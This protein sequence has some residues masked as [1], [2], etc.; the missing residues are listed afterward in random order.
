Q[1]IAEKLYQLGR[2]HQV[3]CVTH[4]PLVAAMADAHYHV[5]KHVV[6]QPAIEKTSSKTTKTKAAKAAVA[7]EEAKAR[8]KIAAQIDKSDTDTDKTAQR[9][10][11]AKKIQ[12]TDSKSGNK[13]SE[14]RTIVKV[15]PLKKAEERRDELAQ[16]AGG[17]SD[18]DAIAFANS[19]LAQAETIRKAG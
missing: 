16:L 19:L 15:T 11:A 14:E 17:K 12:N 10:T 9:K 13:G 1:A 7:A 8:S 2:E 4:Q 6:T 5:G 18:T 3:L